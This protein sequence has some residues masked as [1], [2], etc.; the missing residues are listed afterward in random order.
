MKL[1]PLLIALALGI[2]YS[3]CS[4]G[5]Q[6]PM[7]A[8]RLKE[9]RRTKEAEMNN[10]RSFLH[11][12]NTEFVT[13]RKQKAGETDTLKV[14]STLISDATR[15]RYKDIAFKIRFYTP[16]DD[17]LKEMPFTVTEF[18]LPQSSTP[19]NVRF[20]DVPAEA[21]KFSI[22]IDKVTGESKF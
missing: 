2:S 15:V 14:T 10:P 6:D 3:A 19:I 4:N 20:G 13:R 1:N 21:T 9:E 11:F 7:E 12:S 18:Y 8:A 22:G 16:N 17:L 5:H